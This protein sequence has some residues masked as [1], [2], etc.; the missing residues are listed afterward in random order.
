MRESAVAFAGRYANGECEA[1]E[2]LDK[3]HAE[4]DM[5]IRWRPGRGPYGEHDPP[6]LAPGPIQ[7]RQYGHDKRWRRAR[8]RDEARMVRLVM[9][10]VI[11][12][13]TC[14]FVG[15]VGGFEDG[16]PDPRAAR[17]GVAARRSGLFVAGHVIGTQH[18]ETEQQSRHEQDRRDGAYEKGPCGE[19]RVPRPLP[20][21]TS[22]HPH[23]DAGATTPMTTDHLLPIIPVI[24]VSKGV[25]FLN[26]P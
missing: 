18:T 8:Q 10:V 9:T 23:H 13:M 26:M 12:T 24:A 3:L 25:L 5:P 20:R 11:I 2:G 17:N 14:V 6:D 16:A 21:I 15:H 22:R 4:D 7:Q 19:I 1:S